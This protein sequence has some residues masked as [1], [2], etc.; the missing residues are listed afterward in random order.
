[1]PTGSGMS[2]T[3]KRTERDEDSYYDL[4][5]EQELERINLEDEDLPEGE[6]GEG[7][8]EAEEELPQEE[9]LPS[10]MEEY[11]KRIR[12]QN[13]LF[14]DELKECDELI[15]HEGPVSDAGS[16]ALVPLVQMEMLQLAAAEHGL[17]PEAYRKQILSQ[18]DK[19]DDS[20]SLEGEE[21]IFSADSY[22]SNSAV[23]EGGEP[24]V[25]LTEVTVDSGIC[26]GDASHEGQDDKSLAGSSVINQGVAD[27]NQ[28]DG[29]VIQEIGAVVLAD[30]SCQFR[31]FLR[32]QWHQATEKQRRREA[33]FREKSELTRRQA[34][35]YEQDAISRR[36]KKMEELSMEEKQLTEMNAAKTAEL[37]K[38]LEQ[39]Q[40]E[41]ERELKQ[42]EMSIDELERKTELERKELQNQLELER[43]KQGRQLEG[44]AVKIQSV[45]RGYRVKKVYRD[46]LD[47]KRQTRREEIEARKIREKEIE[48]KQL[49]EKRKAAE[50]ERKRQEEQEKEDK[51]RKE[52]EEQM[53]KEEELRKE[54]EEQLRKEKEE[55]LRK[56]KDEQLRK[57]KEEQL[58]KEKEEKLKKEEEEQMKKE[59]EEQVKKEKEEQQRK[60][61]EERMQK[62]K[63]EQIRKEKEEL[64]RQEKEEK[65]RKEKEELIRK[66]REERLQKEEAEELLRKEKE[67][68]LRKV[69]EEQLQREKEE[70]S[71]R[72]KEEQIRIETEEKL[73][74]EKEE[75]SKSEKDLKKKA[76]GVLQQMQEEH[77]KKEKEDESKELLIGSLSEDL[78]KRRRKWMSEC[79]FWSKI[80]NEPWKTM[81][82]TTKK[83]VKRPS[84]AKKLPAMSVDVILTQAR[85]NSLQQV[86]TVQLADL[87]GCSVSTLGQC[88]HL[89]YLEL[90]DCGVKALEGLTSCKQLHYINLQNNHVQFVDLGDLENLEYVN[91]SSNQLTAVHGLEDCS[92]LRWLDLSNNKII[93][94]G[95]L[96]GL[97]H[98]HT[99]KLCHNQL[100]STQGVGDVPTLQDLHASHNHLQS[101]EDIDKLCLLQTLVLTGNNML[102]FPVL[103]NHV[104][105]QNLL[106]DDNSITSLDSLQSSWLPCLKVLNL[107]QNSIPDLGQMS[108]FVV[109]KDLDV[110]NNQLLDGEEMLKSLMLC[111][112]LERLCV[113]G[114]PGGEESTFLSR[115]CSQFKRL[116]LVDNQ[117]V[118]RA[119][120]PPAVPPKCSFEATCLAQTLAI[121]QIWD[122]HHQKIESLNPTDL[123]GAC[124]AHS[125]MCHTTFDLAVEHRY[126]HEYGEVIIN[127]PAAPSVPKPTGRTT[128]RGR[129][130]VSDV[131]VPRQTNT[132]TS[133]TNDE[134]KAVTAEGGSEFVNVG[135]TPEAGCAC[136]SSVDPTSSSTADTYVHTDSLGHV[137]SDQSV[138][139]AAELIQ[140]AWQGYKARQY[141][142]EERK[143]RRLA[144]LSRQWTYEDEA[145]TTIQ[146][147][148]RGYSLRSRLL[149]ALE[150]AHLEEEEEGEE[151]FVEV[152]LDDFCLDMDDL[153]ADWKPPPTPRIPSSHALLSKP[154]SGR[155]TALHTGGELN[156]PHPPAFPRQAWRNLT[157]PLTNRS[158]P[159]GRQPRPPSSQ[160]SGTDT[161]RTGLSKKEEMLS[162]EWGFKD[163]RT[164]E[165]M[166]QRAKKMKYNADKKKKISKLDPKQKLALFKKLTESTRMLIPVQHPTRKVMPRKEYFQARAREAE[167]KEREKRS[168]VATR[169]S[170]TFEW[171]HTQVGEFPTSDPVKVLI[172][173]ESEN[174]LPRLDSDITAGRRVQLV[175]SPAQLD[176][177]SV[178]SLGE[179]RLRSFSMDE[180][181]PLGVQQVPVQLP[182]IKTNSAPSN[183]VKERMSW[184]TPKKNT[185]IGW[186]GG[187]KRSLKS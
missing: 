59:K 118:Q 117:P 75:Q 62:E 132:F 42:Y 17:D 141:Y 52:K 87:P 13:E 7:V 128:S 93:K 70:Q 157:S 47:K 1:M 12:V 102:E 133:V 91:L 137:S 136:V 49:E 67:E 123:A 124:A 152:D 146:A 30:P 122:C 41:V 2:M 184:R 125:S 96:V 179:N 56:E 100:I 129:C 45:Y 169:A 167:E 83:L 48:L 182:P 121:Q 10:A 162:E 76:D 164:A 18:L 71:R 159:H 88:V 4:L 44:A 36:Q 81:K 111:R 144:G 130:K 37:E 183:R 180:S 109:L 58:K 54:K 142:N 53:K 103:S 113:E 131:K 69:K 9:D 84:S 171:L 97:R 68:Q 94:L 86:T 95:S 110:S 186:G 40:K 176:L 145:A 156:T 14:E 73:R 173:S 34:E 27:H 135:R 155:P 33:L 74:K 151:E 139:L 23:N 78:E 112:H 22:H 6:G 72:E 50:L 16:V 39:K 163:S 105:L 57:E 43:E 89:Q 66:E 90:T 178:S 46:E 104:L 160:A 85:V 153:D 79:V 3:P 64:L 55:Q 177:E 99:L 31:A 60:E 92:N 19:D 28:G 20:L 134:H 11:L 158:S 8:E 82:K 25:L 154:P 98:L 181:S 172:R 143:R 5:I 187:R 61:R 114:N 149:M 115:A 148:W 165:L 161:H 15:Q 120:P 29:E 38:K 80:S 170:R 108:S 168:E 63:E 116:S 150:Y 51:L 166:L 174:G 77:N 24:G 138:T 175:A 106:L 185:D 101:L 32:D 126:A 147:V 35:L 119:Q 140:A 107:A 65:L 21:E 127:W 26:E